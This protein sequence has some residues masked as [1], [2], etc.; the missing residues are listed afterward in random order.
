VKLS[1][2]C[3]RFDVKWTV[4]TRSLERCP[5]RSLIPVLTEF[6]SA[7]SLSP[8]KDLLIPVND[9]VDDHST[10][11]TTPGMNLRG[12]TGLYDD[13]IVIDCEPVASLAIHHPPPD[14]A[15]ISIRESACGIPGAAA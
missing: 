1:A 15:L 13:A 12:R 11:D 2:Y 7:R 5:S 3:P 8:R 9:L 6:G 10:V 14:R 4:R